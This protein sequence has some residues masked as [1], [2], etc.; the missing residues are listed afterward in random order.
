MCYQSS[1]ATATILPSC[2]RYIYVHPAQYV[3]LSQDP[4]VKPLERIQKYH[5][6]KRI[7]VFLFLLRHLLKDIQRKDY[8]KNKE[9]T[10]ETG[11]NEKSM[12]ERS[13]EGNKNEKNYEVITDSNQICLNKVKDLNAEL[14]KKAIF[15][16]SIRE[17]PEEEIDVIRLL[18]IL[19]D[20]RKLQREML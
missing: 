8:K 10:K 14:E 15:V 4:P 1:S 11:S 19:F 13:K 2:V 18:D 17:M 12:V 20:A 16:A 9:N 3:W 5:V 7:Q 6:Q